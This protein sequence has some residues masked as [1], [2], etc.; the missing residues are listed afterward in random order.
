MVAE[1]IDRPLAALFLGLASVLLASPHLHA[2]PPAGLLVEVRGTVGIPGW[3]RVDPPTLWAAL[4]A[5]HADADDV[6]DQALQLGDAVVVGPTGPTV[7]RVGQPLL[8]GRPLSVLDDPAE[9]FADLPGVGDDD[10]A[11]LGRPGSDARRTPPGRIARWS[12]RA[13]RA[14]VAAPPKVI[15]VNLDTAEALEALPGVGPALAARIVAYRQAHG[16]FREVA[17]LDA[18]SGIGPATLARIKP[19]AT[20]TAR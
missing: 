5:A 11:R 18:V 8:L 2:A 16:P 19:M 20:V 1:A 6:T 3:H 9:A 12:E 7:T 15:N 17:D 14:V 13:P 10:V 4:E